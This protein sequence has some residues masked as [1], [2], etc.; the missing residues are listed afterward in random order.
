MSYYKFSQ[1]LTEKYGEK[2]WKIPVDAGFSCPNR[3]VQ[4]GREGCIFCRVDSFSRMLSRQGMD[5]G[6]QVMQGMARGRE[7]GIKKFIIYFQASTNTYAPVAVL[8]RLYAQ[9][10]ECEGVVGLSIATR[11]D[12]LEAPV[13]SVLGELAQK[14]HVWVEIGLQSVHNRSLAFLNRGHTYEDYRHAVAQLRG[15][16]L[17]ICAHVMLGLPYETRADM[18]ATADEIAAC[19]IHEVKIHPLLVLKDTALA[20]LYAARKIHSLDLD[21]YISLACDFMERLPSTMVIQRVTA[22]APSSMLL[23][24]QWAAHKLPVIRGIGE[25]FKRRGTRQGIYFKGFRTGI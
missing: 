21:E 16:P 6:E 7:K 25:E 18:Q 23:A 5:I 9:A 10:L 14:T 11:P 22:E 8:R 2:V 20:E 4:S 15:L 13:L 12:C 19:P 24:P 3:D 17:R 1:F